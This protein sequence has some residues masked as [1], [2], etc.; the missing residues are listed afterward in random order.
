MVPPKWPIASM[1]AW[2][3]GNRP[4]LYHSACKVSSSDELCPRLFRD[5]DAV[6]HM[7]ALLD[8]RN[9]ADSNRNSS[10]GVFSCAENIS[11][12]TVRTPCGRGSTSCERR[13][14]KSIFTNLH[15]SRK[16]ILSTRALDALVTKR[17]EQ[18]M[19]K[20]SF[21]R[22]ISFLRPGWWIIHLVGITIVYT[23][24]HILWR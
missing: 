8:L 13:H 16:V 22:K 17:E 6:A 9:L 2:L 23:L 15:H 19:E 4:K 21:S 11:L 18:N 10:A 1:P 3:T 24:G 12:F 7:I 5:L 20:G 14:M